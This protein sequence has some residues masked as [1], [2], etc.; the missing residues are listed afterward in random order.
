MTNIGRSDGGAGQY[1]GPGGTISAALQKKYNAYL[2]LL[3]TDTKLYSPS[4]LVRAF[5]KNPAPLPR[6]C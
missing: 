2:G 1:N 3:D 4:A 6:A 5:T